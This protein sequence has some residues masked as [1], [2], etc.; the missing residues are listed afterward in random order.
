MRLP[1]ASPR[2]LQSDC[3]EASSSAPKLPCVDEAVPWMNTRIGFSASIVDSAT[4][5]AALA[6]LAERCVTS[7][8]RY[9]PSPYGSRRSISQ[10]ANLVVAQAPAVI[11]WPSPTSLT[12]S[13][14]R[15]GSAISASTASGRSRSTRSA[16]AT[17]SRTPRS[18]TLVRGSMSIGTLLPR[19]VSGRSTARSWR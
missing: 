4:G 19:T 3:A 5:F 16:L 7:P 11:A 6:A 18:E 15:A 14:Q 9:R 12:N 17:Q 13:L 8:K 10:S 2:A 1:N